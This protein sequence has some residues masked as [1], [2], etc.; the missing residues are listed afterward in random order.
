MKSFF[1]E[2]LRL[3]LG[4][5]YAIAGF[6]KVLE[7]NSFLGEIM[8]YGLVPTSILVPFGVFI[9]AAEIMLG[10]SLI[11]K[12]RIRLT[13][14]LLGIVTCV[15][16]IALLIISS[17]GQGVNC[18]CFGSFFPEKVGVIILMRDMLLIAGCF[19]LSLR[20]RGMAECRDAAVP[21]SK[22]VDP[23]HR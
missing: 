15:F 23:G 4:A 5:V 10:F 7:F 9:I 18:G 21:S 13:A 14:F 11:A 6:I 17:R 12:F 22:K 20:D 16:T 8:K 19:W 3:F 2:S 1:A